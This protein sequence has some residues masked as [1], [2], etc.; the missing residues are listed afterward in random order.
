MADQ[1]A[2]GNG[3]IALLCRAGSLAATI[4]SLRFLT[5]LAMITLNRG[6]EG[7]GAGRSAQS[8]SERQC[9]LAPAAGAGRS[10]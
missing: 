7:T 9:R 3:P 1:A 10:A 4:R 2:S 8:Q 5:P 6:V